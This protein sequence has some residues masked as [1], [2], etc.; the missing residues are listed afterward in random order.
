MKRADGSYL[1]TG[2]IYRFISALLLFALF[3]A[4]R[5]AFRANV[6]LCDKYCDIIRAASLICSGALS[7]IRFPVAEIFGYIFLIFFGFYLLFMIYKMCVSGHVMARILRILSNGT[8]IFA[9]FVVVFFALYG[10]AYYASPISEKLELE[11]VSSADVYKLRHLTEHM[12]DKANE[13]ADMVPRGIDGACEFGSFDTMNSVAVKSFENAQ[14]SYEMISGPFA[15][16]KKTVRKNLLSRFGY[17]GIFIPFTGE[18]VVNVQEPDSALIFTM[19]HEMS[20]RLAIAPEDEANFIAFL[21]CRA[22]TDR[23]AN[24]SGYMIAYR[25]CLSALSS[26]DAAAAGEVSYGAGKNLTHDLA[27]YKDFLLSCNGFLSKL[28]DKIND[29][30]L[31]SQG[32]SEGSGSYGKVVELLLA[33]YSSAL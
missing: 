31:K 16:V 13:Y 12:R 15:P 17:S 21:V 19:A 11:S 20:H 29:K 30:Y 7:Y 18:A 9:A 6:E 4:A 23:R 8:V 28:A 2:T 10:A 5:T 27:E 22:S 26:L 33:E 32:Q 25:Y 3:F 1:N 24:Y 14:L